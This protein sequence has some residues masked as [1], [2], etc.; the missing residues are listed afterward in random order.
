MFLSPTLSLEMK[1]HTAQAA[2]ELTVR[3][4]MIVKLLSHPPAYTLCVLVP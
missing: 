2:L 1:S 3:L 4:N